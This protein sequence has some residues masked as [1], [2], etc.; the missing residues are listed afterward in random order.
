[1][2][3][4]RRPQGPPE[5]DPSRIGSRRAAG[6]SETWS[7][8]PLDAGPQAGRSCPEAGGGGRLSSS[9]PSA[10]SIAISRC[11][12]CSSSP[13]QVATLCPPPPGYRKLQPR[14]PIPPPQPTAR[15]RSPFGA[16][17]SG[18]KMVSCDLVFQGVGK[19]RFSMPG[20]RATCKNATSGQGRTFW[21]YATKKW[22]RQQNPHQHQAPA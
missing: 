17:R 3:L 15:W 21:Q 13:V 14:H 11:T 4:G 8:C 22:A 2:A 18:W 7:L 1:M 9:S 6:T 12:P 19:S 5:R 16:D 20:C 10:A